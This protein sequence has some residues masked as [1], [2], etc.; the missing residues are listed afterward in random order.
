MAHRQCN[1]AL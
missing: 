1:H